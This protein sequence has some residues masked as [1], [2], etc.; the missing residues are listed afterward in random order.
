M[1]VKLTTDYTYLLGSVRHYHKIQR[2]SSASHTV[3]NCLLKQKRMI[4]QKRLRKHLYSK[5][6][7]T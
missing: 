4:L 6:P 3:S 5:H 1:K 7:N 2:F